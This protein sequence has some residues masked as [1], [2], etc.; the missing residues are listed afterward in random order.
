MIFK[1]YTDKFTFE[2]YAVFAVPFPSVHKVEK[3]H[4]ILQLLAGALVTCEFVKEIQARTT[5]NF[6]H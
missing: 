3:M 6:I 5:S 2:T 4:I 1:S